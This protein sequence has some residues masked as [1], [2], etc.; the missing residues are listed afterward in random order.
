M[1]AIFL[2]YAVWKTIPP[3]SPISFHLT[4]YKKNAMPQ[5]FNATSFWKTCFIN[6]FHEIPCNH[7]IHTCHN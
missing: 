7:S 3:L 6:N 1:N 5:V 4:D 2:A